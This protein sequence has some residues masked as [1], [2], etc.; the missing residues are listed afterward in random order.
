[1]D[2]DIEAAPLAMKIL[3][4]GARLRP[5]GQVRARNNR[6]AARL[7]DGV[8]HAATTLFIEIADGDEGSFGGKF[9][10]ARLADAGGG[11]RDKGALP[12]KLPARFKVHGLFPRV[13]SNPGHPA[14]RPSSAAGILR[15][16]RGISASIRRN[17]ILAWKPE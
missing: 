11:A 6:L 15:K 14:R 9:P 10:G 7:L 4:G 16:R 3:D 13:G 2:G 5:I 17:K 8:G 1:M 12:G